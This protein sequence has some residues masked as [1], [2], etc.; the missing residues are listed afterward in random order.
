[1]S[2]NGKIVTPMLHASPLCSAQIKGFGKVASANMNFLDFLE[3]D[4]ISKL[5]L[6]VRMKFTVPDS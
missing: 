4:F 6:S 1:M 3:R 5:I 2:N